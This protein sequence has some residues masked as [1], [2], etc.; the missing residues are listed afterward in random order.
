M[1]WDYNYFPSLFGGE[2]LYDNITMDPLTFFPEHGGLYLT[3]LR[4]WAHGVP[5]YYL[6][7]FGNPLSHPDSNDY[8]GF[9]LD[10]ARVTPHFSLSLGARRDLQTFSK[11][12][13]VNNPICAPSGKMP[14][15]GTNLAPR[16]G[17]GY[18]I[19]DEHPVMV[20]AGFGIF[21]TRIPRLYQSAV[22]AGR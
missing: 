10:M 19:R 3:P 2:Y 13:M 14:L 16:I 4:A 20:R 7:S 8:A 22:W 18:A 6:Q 11:T 1:T 15:R 17:I 5:R 21:F 9:V 12:G